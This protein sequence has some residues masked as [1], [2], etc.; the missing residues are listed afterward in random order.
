MTPADVDDSVPADG[1]VQGDE[2]AVY[3]DKAYDDA[4]RRKRLKAQGIEPRIMYQARAQPA[5]QA[6][7]DGV[8]Q[9]AGSGADPGGRR[10]AVRDHEAGLRAT[11]GCAP[12]WARNDVQLQNDVRRHQPAPGA[13]P[14]AGLKGG[15]FSSDAEQAGQKW[16][17]NE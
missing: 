10:A 6:L 15:L 11:A 17:G 13:R 12:A 16:S 9:A 3:A 14:R 5:A 7:A 1:L 4:A 2:Q 8:Q